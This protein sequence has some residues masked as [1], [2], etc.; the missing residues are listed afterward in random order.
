MKI[1]KLSNFMVDLKKMTHFLQNDQP[2]S[3]D[4]LT[5]IKYLSGL[6]G[7]EVFTNLASEAQD[8][9]FAPAYDS[10]IARRVSLPSKPDKRDHSNKSRRILI[11]NPEGN[12]VGTVLWELGT[13]VA[14][15]IV[16]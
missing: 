11:E 2:V 1:Q 10:A 6:S 14:W 9:D 3:E 12:V 8:P 5:R 7:R 15:V 16:Y 13:D 4:I